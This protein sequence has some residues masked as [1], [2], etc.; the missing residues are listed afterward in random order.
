MKEKVGDALLLERATGADAP[1]EV[2]R[3]LDKKNFD[4]FEN[5]WRPMLKEARKR[6]RSAEEAAQFDAQDSHWEWVEKAVEA[7]RVIGRDTYAVEAA[8]LTQGLMLIDVRFGRL[9]LQ[10][11]KELVYIDLLATA[12]WN[13]PK[14]APGGRLKG[15]GRVLV[16]TAISLSADLG[17]EGRIGLHSLPQSESWYRAVGFAEVEFDSAKRMSYFEMTA[18]DALAF[19]TD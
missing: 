13:R 11:G 12:P 3:T 16:G 10:R 8:G 18:A 4:D 19:V 17:F 15:V 14:L 5:L 2:F 7:E 1:A 6:A 9:P